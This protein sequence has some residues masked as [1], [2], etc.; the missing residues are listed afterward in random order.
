MQAPLAREPPCPRATPPLLRAEAAPRAAPPR[1]PAGKVPRASPSPQEVWTHACLLHD[2]RQVL[3]LAQLFH[4][5][6]A[7]TLAHLLHL[8]EQFADTVV[9]AL[10]PGAG[11]GAVTCQ[12]LAAPTQGVETCAAADCVLADRTLEAGTEDPFTANAAGERRWERQR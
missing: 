6:Q 8:A 11:T 9:A 4:L 10:L 1:L 12:A 7:W 3:T 2:R 5:R